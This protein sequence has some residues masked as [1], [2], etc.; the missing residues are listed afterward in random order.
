MI[1]LISKAKK[2]ASVEKVLIQ[3]IQALEEM[4]GIA[5][6]MEINRKQETD[7]ETLI[8]T[9]QE[10][11]LIKMFQEEIAKNQIKK[12]LKLKF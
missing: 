5:T 7:M 3:T 4:T 6:L 9:K 10:M 1:I 2:Q 12:S 8:K 11:G